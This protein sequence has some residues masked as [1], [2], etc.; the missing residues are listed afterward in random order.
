MQPL[1][2]DHFT[3]HLKDSMHKFFSADPINGF[4]SQSNDEFCFP[5]LETCCEPEELTS[6]INIF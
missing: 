3:K 6:K 5:T 2:T 4:P 1:N